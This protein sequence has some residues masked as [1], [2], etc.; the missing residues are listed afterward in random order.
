[1]PKEG[2]AI[3]LELFEDTHKEVPNFTFEIVS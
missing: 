2:F 1:M 3:M